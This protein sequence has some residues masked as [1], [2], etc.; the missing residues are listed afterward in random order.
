M[1][2]Y[3]TALCV[4]AVLYALVSGNRAG[5]ATCRDAMRAIVLG[6]GPSFRRAVDG[7]LDLREHGAQLMV[8]ACAAGEEEAVALL[9]ERGVD[10]DAAFGGAAPLRA[11]AFCGDTAIVRRLLRAGA[12]PAGHSAC[13]ETALDVARRQGHDETAAVLAGCPGNGH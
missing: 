9:L 6:D 5:S 3:L 4:G 1:R 2:G 10:P 8:Y 13:G 11:A 12:D 7:G